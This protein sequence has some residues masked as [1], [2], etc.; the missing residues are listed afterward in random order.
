MKLT[1]QSLK[2]FSGSKTNFII[3]DVYFKNFGLLLRKFRNPGNIPCNQK[4]LPSADFVV[5]Q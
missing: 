2:E 5:T 3:N 1:M 4:S